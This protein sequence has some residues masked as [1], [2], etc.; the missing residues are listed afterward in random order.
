MSGPGDPR[1]LAH[2]L[3]LESFE[4]QFPRFRREIIVQAKRMQG[5]F[6]SAWH[7]D[8]S[9]PLP[10]ALPQQSVRKSYELWQ[11]TGL[12]LIQN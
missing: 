8:F 3:A 7:A 10:A 11:E 2:A 1:E 5:P 4:P 9:T 6:I 12:G